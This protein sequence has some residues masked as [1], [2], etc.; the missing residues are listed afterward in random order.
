MVTKMRRRKVH[1]YVEGGNP[2]TKGPL[3]GQAREAFA[4]LFSTPEVQVVVKAHGG[5]DDTLDAFYLAR[6]GKKHPPDEPVLLLIDAEGP[7]ADIHKPWAHLKKC[8][9]G[10][11]DADVL[12]MV[13]V[14]ETWMLADPDALRAVFPHKLDLAKL[15]APTANVEGLEKAHVY[16]SLEQAT[17]ACSAPYGKSD[18]SFRVV[19]ELNPETLKKRLPSFKRAW[20]RIHR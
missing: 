5:R 6:N 7:V 16:R 13:Q 14:M 9:E 15:P 1:L 17:R 11:P 10:V 4:A 19:A 12:L 8:V 18:H 3:S 2:S 20:D